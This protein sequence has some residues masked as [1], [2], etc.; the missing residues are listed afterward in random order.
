LNADPDPDPATQINA[1]PCGSGYGSES[2][3]LLEWMVSRLVQDGGVQLTEPGKTH[4]LKLNSDCPLLSTRHRGAAAD[5]QVVQDVEKSFIAVSGKVYQLP[6]GSSLV[7][8]HLIR[9]AADS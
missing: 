6:V 9:G 7:F 1:D 5:T 8:P 4:E 2:E 3:T